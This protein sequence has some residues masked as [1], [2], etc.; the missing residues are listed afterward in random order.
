[1]VFSCQLSN[2]RSNRHVKWFKSG[3]ELSADDP[4]YEMGWKND[5]HTLCIMKSVL[6]DAGEF[7]IQVGDVACVASLIVDGEVRL[8]SLG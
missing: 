1:M 5:T 4:H 3:A 6:E 7:A 8:Q 2:P